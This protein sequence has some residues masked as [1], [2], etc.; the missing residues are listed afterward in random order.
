M[1]KPIFTL[2]GMLS[3]LHY[4]KVNFFVDQIKSI[5]RCKNMLTLHE[6][7]QQSEVFCGL[8]PVT[9]TAPPQEGRQRS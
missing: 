7:K 4:N 8:S 5:W 3:A 1:E 6:K 2:E 9:R